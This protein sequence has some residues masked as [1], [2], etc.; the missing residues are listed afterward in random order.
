MLPIKDL[1]NPASD[2]PVKDL[3]NPEPAQAG[4][5]TDA[6]TTV[7]QTEVQEKKCLDCSRPAEKDKAKC[8]PCLDTHNQK[9]RDRRKARKQQKK[10]DTCPEDLDRDDA[11]T[12]TNCY[13][14]RKEYR[15]EWDK[16]GPKNKSKS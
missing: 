13:N 4:S 16:N 2:I 12:C 6:N 15:E 1:L 10:C 5:S 9:A 11:S 8:R 7:G 3:L 14:K